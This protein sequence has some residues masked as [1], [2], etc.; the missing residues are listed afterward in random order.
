ME[1]V[2]RKPRIAGVHKSLRRLRAGLIAYAP[3][4]FK[5]SVVPAMVLYS[6]Y[7]TEPE[8]TLL[9]LLNPLF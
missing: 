9:D 5:L 3:F 8:A 4:V 2:K 1:V 6:M 7:F